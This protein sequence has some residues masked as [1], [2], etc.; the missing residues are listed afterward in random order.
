MFSCLPVLK[1]SSNHPNDLGIE[2]VLLACLIN[3]PTLPLALRGWIV[4]A[5]LPCC[6]MQLPA[7]PRVR[8]TRLTLTRTSPRGT[9]LTL[10]RTSPTGTRLTLTRTSPRGTRSPVK[11][12]RQA[13]SPRWSWDAGT[14]G[15]REAER[16]GGRDGVRLRSRLWGSERQGWVVGSVG[17]LREEASAMDLTRACGCETPGQAGAQPDQ[18]RCS[19]GG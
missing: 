12:A 8:G 16:D 1:A 5:K 6:F 3:S 14:Q 10:T 2:C 15:R 7:P 9:R 18:G 11:M 13:F 19:G 17:S 4:C